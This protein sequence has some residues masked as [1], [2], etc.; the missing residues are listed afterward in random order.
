[1]K[2]QIHRLFLA[3]LAFAIFA[4]P[5]RLSAFDV[6]QVEPSVVRVLNSISD[7]EGCSGSAFVVSSNASGSILATNN[8]VVDR[9][10]ALL[11]VRK[12]HQQI[13]AYGAQVLWSDAHY[14]L[15]IL[16]VPELQ[17]P[18]LTLFSEP[19][20]LASDAYGLG[21]PGMADD[22]Q[23]QQAF[24]LACQKASQSSGNR[25][26][27]PDPSGQGVRFVEM[28]VSKGGVRRVLNGSWNNSPPEFM[29][30]EHDV[31]IMHGNSGGPLLD[32]GYR[33][34]GVNTAGIIT[35]EDGKLCWS[36]H[37][38]VLIQAL[39]NLNIPIQVTDRALPASTGSGSGT[40]AA[41][42]LSALALGGMAWMFLRPP[43]LI[44]ET[45]TQYVRRQP[46]EIA[47]PNRGVP[48]APAQAPVSASSGTYNLTGI[49]TEPGRA[50]SVSLHIDPQLIASA[51]GKIII[52]RKQA[53]SHLHIPNTSVSGQHATLL[54]QNGAVTIQD[55]NSSNG[56]KLNGQLLPPLT[57][58]RLNLGDRIQFGDIQ[59][60]W[61]RI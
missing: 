42:L 34:L 60:E 38:S 23:G 25:F 58:H 56:T 20:P 2:K 3:I 33:V 26:I 59:M 11:I 10:K 24:D 27:L 36:S 40:Y 48:G 4:T 21:F 37:A 8:H 41:I 17:A 32:A 46:R 49:N 18:P 57:S 30:I 1:M 50:A 16:K 61:R 54:F 43:A 7:T 5:H 52:G 13:E 12:Y 15:A 29:R 31:N 19:P 9:N 51:S 45:Y 53:V 55:R 44:R 39:R 6:K 35:A 22:A 47:T 14:D 28:S